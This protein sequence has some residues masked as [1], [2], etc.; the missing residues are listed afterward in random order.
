MGFTSSMML[1]A[2]STDTNAIATGLPI[3]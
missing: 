1:T 3:G 2:S